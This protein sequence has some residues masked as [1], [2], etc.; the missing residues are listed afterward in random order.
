MATIGIQWMGSG[1]VDFGTAL[2]RLRPTQFINLKQM[3]EVVF[4]EIQSSFTLHPEDV[5]R[6]GIVLTIRGRDTF[7]R[8]KPG[9]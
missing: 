9:S 7:R 2:R 3:D 4:S 8:V 6:R 5:L 1:N